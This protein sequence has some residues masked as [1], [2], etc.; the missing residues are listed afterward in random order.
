MGRVT[1]AVFGTILVLA[2]AAPAGAAV[3]CSAADAP[4]APHCPSD[5][6]IA[7]L[8][9][10]YRENNVFF[11]RGGSTLDA[12][13]QAQIAL[14]ARVLSTEALSNTC[15]RLVGHSDSSGDRSVNQRISERRADAVEAKLGELMGPA[16]LPMVAEGAGEDALLASLPSTHVAQRR[17]TIW[18]RACPAG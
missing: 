18:A 1:T 11:P 9:Q 3:D 4:G 10:D 15:L 12:D 17:V 5:A 2:T 7:A 14:L 13:A 8:G 16:A 6:R